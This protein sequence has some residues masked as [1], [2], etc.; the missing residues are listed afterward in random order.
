MKH[1]LIV[2]LTL[3]SLSSFASNKSGFPVD[4]TQISNKNILYKVSQAGNYIHL[5]ISTTDK[6]TAM[7]II[8]N[9]L[10]IYYDIKG[11]EKKDVYVKY[12]YSNES[13][14]FQQGSLENIDVNAIDL[15]SMIEKLP[16]EAEYGSFEE[17]QEF[18]KDLN[19]L[20]IAIENHYT[21]SS[22]LFE[23]SIKIPKA[24][25][26]SQENSDFS[27]LS[28]GVVANKMEGTV[29]KEREQGQNQGMRSGGGRRGNGSGGGR[30]GARGQNEQQ[31][32]PT[33][34]RVT[35]DFWFDAE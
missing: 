12:P 5:N 26:A 25:I 28:I 10:T 15:N 32:S 8:R 9:G 16:A 6:K 7:S 35:V 24:K 20:D 22:Q 23:F 17:K 14:S 2:L 34:E 30:G 1:L 3:S 29:N 4:T 19:N 31:S 33:T 13:R 27:K 11:K 18:N 21:A